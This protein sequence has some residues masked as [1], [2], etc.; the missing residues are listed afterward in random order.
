VITAKDITIRSR[1][2]LA[3]RCTDFEASVMLQAARRITERE[4]VLSRGLAVEQYV[5]QLKEQ[6]LYKLYGDIQ[7]RLR[8][9]MYDVK[10]RVMDQEEPYLSKMQAVDLIDRVFNSVTDLIDEKMKVD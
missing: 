3:E 10:F 8:N 1:K 5:R 7:A 4:Q 9:D 6:I 2:N